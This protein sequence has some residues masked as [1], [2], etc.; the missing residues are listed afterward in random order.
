MCSGLGHIH[1]GYEVHMRELFDVIS[2]SETSMQFYLLKGAGKS[3]GMEKTM[4]CAKR[5]SRISLFCKEIFKIH[6]PYLEQFTFFI[7]SIYYILIKKPSV[8]YCADYMLSAFLAKFKKFFGLKYTIL[9]LNGNNYA[10]PYKHWDITHQVLWNNY[11][12]AQEHSQIRL[13]QYM[14]YHGFKDET[15]KVDSNEIRNKYNIPIKSKI[16]LSVGNL[17]CSVKRMD[18][19]IKEFSKILQFDKDHFLIL[20]GEQNS[21]TKIIKTLAKNI[22]PDEKY[23]IET[24]EH[25]EMIYYY[26]LAD[27]FCLASLKEGFGLVFI[28]ALSVGL[29]VIAHDDPVM[30]E[31][32]SNFGLFGNLENEGVLS[33][34]I[35][36]CEKY[37]SNSVKKERKN[38]V[39]NKYGWSH[40]LIHYQELFKSC[41]N[42]VNSH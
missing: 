1:R 25:K 3:H 31:V 21:E 11:Y 29:P 22:L 42:S 39:S 38:Y 17:D 10:P 33:K 27:V 15:C 6:P 8:I 19:L 9:F 35:I 41:I 14:V 32:I 28:E 4:W 30:R 16:I 26:S 34:L 13:N 18:Y 2:D 24:V 7:S 40:L 23:L 36:E 12:K 37:N 5:N 20:L